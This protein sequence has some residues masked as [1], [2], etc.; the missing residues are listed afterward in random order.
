M[1][2]VEQQLRSKKS[3]GDVVDLPATTAPKY[4]VQNG[5]RTVRFF[6]ET[7]N[8]DNGD[9]LHWTSLSAA[10][11]VRT[12]TSYTGNSAGI[13]LKVRRE[14][15]G[16]FAVNYDETGSIAVD[17]VSARAAD[18][19]IE[20]G[21]ATVVGQAIPTVTEVDVVWGGRTR[22]V[23]VRNGEFS[24]SIDRLALGSNPVELEAFN[25]GTSLGRYKFDAEL[26]VDALT[27][28]AGFAEDVM[29]TVQLSGRATPLSRV[30]IRHGEKVLTT[31]RVDASG[32]WATTVNAPNMPG[33]YDLDAVQVIR[34]ADHG[35]TALA[36]DYGTGTTITSPGNGFVLQPGE[37]L[38]LRGQAQNAAAIRVYE[39]G[40]PGTVLGTATAS[41][42]DGTWR[43]ANLELDDREYVLIAESISK[44]YNRTRAEMTINPGKSTV[45][46]PTAAATFHADV[47]KKATVA[48]TGVDGA[49]ITVKEGTKVL[50]TATVTNG[51]WSTTIDPI[52]AGKHTLTIEQTG[53]DGTQTATT[54]IDYGIGVAITTPTASQIVPGVTTVAGTSQPGANV[55]VTVGGRSVNATV[56]GTTWTADVE[57]A[58]STTP[59]TITAT[60]QSKGALTTTA[61]KQVTASAAQQLVNAAITEPSSHQYTPM[62]PTTISGI[63]TPYSTVVVKNQWNVTVGTVTANKDGAWS[64]TRAW[65]PNAAYELTPTQ[66]LADGRTQTGSAFS[67]RPQMALTP[68]TID[69]ANPAQYTPG[70]S[71]AFTGTA[72][73]GATIT[74][75]NQWGSLVF[76][77]RADPT[78]G[79][80]SASR[81]YGPSAKYIFTITQTATNGQSDRIEDFHLDPKSAWA[82]ATLTSHADN[83]VYRAGENT[84]RGTGTAGAE[85]TAKTQ[86]GGIIGTA[87]VQDNGEWAFVRYLGPSAN[88]VITFTATKGTDSNTFDIHLNGPTT[89]PLV[90]T[91]PTADE[92]YTPGTPYT[93]RGT[94]SSFATITVKSRSSN[95]VFFTTTADGNGNWSSTR[96]W[97]PTNTYQLQLTQK[98]LQGKEDSLNLTWSPNPSN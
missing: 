25:G 62:Q 57:I 68:L 38:T 69:N 46:D 75:K 86:W 34:G 17:R 1:S 48:G 79:A 65:G 44:G 43:L 39:K 29:E 8:T 28:N 4:E 47:A 13:N 18:L 6:S 33:V 59:T 10:V 14:F 74:A 42:T 40:K 76:E 20:N 80:W 95:T 63:A 51:T 49:T 83:T 2:I 98:N 84:F 81:Q 66:T 71:Y 67:L 30:D 53:I 15:Q 88:Y 24:T 87:T 5:G 11:K 41:A 90:L 26:V 16:N 61:E 22:T 72:T 60:Q 54:E 23:P 94:A 58:P 89:A 3:N 97:G 64:F 37:K 27:A 31:A 35:T 9:D 85:I 77:T 12:D 52:G 45:A 36:I 73:P 82:D 70:Q 55:T 92:H 91:A 78:T 50:G 19:D 56:S 21:T 93:F 7:S 32:T 96:A